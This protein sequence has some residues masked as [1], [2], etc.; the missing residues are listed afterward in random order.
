M[1][2]TSAD[3]WTAETS[4]FFTS[5]W[6]WSPESWG[7]IGWTGMRGFGRRRNLLQELSDPFIAVIYVTGR[8]EDDEALHGR[9]AGFYLI[10]HEM[11]DRNAFT[12]PIHHA[13]EPG[14]W[15]H[16]LQALRAF[17]YLPEYRLTVSDL[18]PRLLEQ[19]RA[20]AG[21]GKVLNDP[22]QINPLRSTPWVEVDVYQGA[23]GRAAET[24]AELLPT[25][26]YTRPGPA[27]RNGYVVSSSAQQ[28]KRH[29]YILR[30]DGCTDAYLGKP[31]NGRQIYKIGI[32]ASPEMRRQSFQKAMPRGAFRWK[33]HHSTA[34][35]EGMSPSSFDEAI[36]GENA[37]K[38]H[39]A[40]LAS[41]EHLGG[42]FYLAKE[43]DIEEAWHLGCADNDHADL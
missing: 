4:V 17:S 27:N 21:M 35:Q 11:G 33:I 8:P 16:S 25:R 5:F 18:D 6:G 3:F 43:A 20:V 14:K 10:S 7:G 15:Q 39:L 34:K 30:L 13:L 26:G 31:S 9:I 2:A 12:H 36:A 1:T 23:S 29:L 38:K 40:A 19:A 42:E 22:L 41:S 24:E 28:L 32:S 37:M